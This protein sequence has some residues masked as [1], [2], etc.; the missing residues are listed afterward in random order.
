MAYSKKNSFSKKK[1]TIRR[2]MK[3]GGPNE[4]LIRAERL[5]P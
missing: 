3:G 4:D 1:K 5:M 2:N